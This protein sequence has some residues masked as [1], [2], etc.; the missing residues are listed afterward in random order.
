[1][2]VNIWRLTHPLIQTTAHGVEIAD[3]DNAQSDSSGSAVSDAQDAS[4]ES[5]GGSGEETDPPTPR[6]PSYSSRDSPKLATEVVLKQST[7]GT[8]ADFPG[9][10]EHAITEAPSV[11]DGSAFA[12]HLIDECFEAPLGQVFELLYGAD[13]SFMQEF[14]SKNQ[15]LL[16][17]QVSS[18]IE[19][20]GKSVRSTSYVKPLSGPIGPKQTRCLLD[21]VIEMKDFERCVQIVQTTT[22]PDVPS[23]DAFAVK[24]RYSLMWGPH[25]T[26]R[27]VSNCMIEWTKNSWI[28]G[29]IEKGVNSGQAQFTA[30]LVEAIRHHIAMNSTD[31]KKRLKAKKSKEKSEGGEVPTI[32]VQAQS[33][34]SNSSFGLSGIV[35]NINTNV[36]IFVLLL[37]MMIAMMRMQRTI[38]DLAKQAHNSNEL[39]LSMRWQHEESDLWTWLAE[40]TSRSSKTSVLANVRRA[41][42]PLN[43]EMT[44]LQI[45]EAL[46]QQIEVLKRS[47]NLARKGSEEH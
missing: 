18:F 36:L 28:K 3:D 17:V 34:P 4:D 2:I 46:K 13:K 11:G 10:T 29:P 6:R 41:A 38:H 7:P 37:G 9:P 8:A 5:S 12:K 43:P 14:L 44:Q 30:D 25:N 40:R 31:R 21:D 1:M 45:R 26:T 23:G 19:K 33:M 42:V 27:M 47:E 32:T 22:S 20:S 24:T 35:E 15:K 39:P 16:D